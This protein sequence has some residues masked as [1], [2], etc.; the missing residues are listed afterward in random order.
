[1]ART[2]AGR[3]W[4]RG[5][6]AALA[7]VG[8]IGC[9]PL[10]TIAFLTHRDE[11]VPAPYRLRPAEGEKADKEKEIKVLVLCEHATGVT[12][13][14]AGADRELAGMM[15][16]RLP[17]L[18]K[19]NKDKLAVVPAAELDKFKMKNPD[20]RGMRPARIGKAL[21][22]DYVLDVNV[23]NV[24]V[25]QPGSGRKIYEGRAEVE[26][27]VYDTTAPAADGPLHHY[28]HPYLY[29]KSGMK[30]VEDVPL[31]RFKQEFLERLALELARKHVDY[32]QAATIGAD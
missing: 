12:F 10:S 9:N 2:V 20:W 6:W 5:V 25:Y 8:T 19:E 29:P 7:V 24:N 13:E 14:F 21:G 17:E 32:K 18:A 30:V 27:E 22:A 31:N 28:T 3:W 23:G 1:M 4:K 26:V 15:A 16:K 11:P